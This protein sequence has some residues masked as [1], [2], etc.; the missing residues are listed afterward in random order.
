[1]KKC[2]LLLCAVGLLTDAVRQAAGECIFSAPHV[3]LVGLAPCLEQSRIRSFFVKFI[4]C[5]FITTTVISKVSM[6]LQFLCTLKEV[7]VLEGMTFLV[8]EGWSIHKWNKVD[9]DWLRRASEAFPC[10]RV[11]F[12][13][14]EPSLNKRVFFLYSWR[15]GL[16][17]GY[18]YVSFRLCVTLLQAR[19]GASILFTHRV[20]E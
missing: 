13:E 11:C 18:A 17:L 19:F 16:L 8:P 15:N 4:S 6:Y 20:C 2:G 7:R 14:E 9:V 5:V 12:H 3:V 10:P 1:M